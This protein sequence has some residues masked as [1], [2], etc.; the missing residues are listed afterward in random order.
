M[1]TLGFL[2]LAGLSSFILF[3]EAIAA[4]A[5]LRDSRSA[6]WWGISWLF[7]G[8]ANVATFVA[9]PPFV[10]VFLVNVG[11]SLAAWAALVWREQ[12]LVKTAGS[13]KGALLA[14]GTMGSTLLVA[15]V[16]V[17][18]S[19]E[20]YV[21]AVAWNLVPV[22]F[23][24]LAY[25]R[26]PSR[27][28]TRPERFQARRLL[29]GSCLGVLPVFLSWMMVTSLALPGLG[30]GVPLFMAVM[31]PWILRS[32]SNSDPRLNTSQSGPFLVNRTTDGVVFV[33][34]NG[35][36][37]DPNPAFS[38]LLGWTSDEISGQSLA[39]LG[40]EP[41]GQ[42][43]LEALS[44]LTFPDWE[45]DLRF[46]HRDGDAVPVRVVFHR[47]H[48]GARE[49]TGAVLLLYDQRNPQ[50]RDLTTRVDEVTSLSNRR[51][52][53]ELLEAE[54]QRVSQYG[55]TL[56]ALWIT[57]LEWESVRQKFGEE[58][59]HDGLQRLAAILQAGLRKTD[60]SGRIDEAVFVVV[61]PHTTEERAT[62]VAR[63]LER[64][65]HLS[66]EEENAGLQMEVLAGQVN[67]TD[68]S[69]E[70]FLSRIRKR[71]AV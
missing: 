12:I 55:G 49:A 34:A 46:R 23:M 65:F 16:A 67:N 54:Y 53:L 56:S 35:Q 31:A 66:A 18:W 40:G 10:Q 5:A 8:A 38:G 28:W 58:T 51:W 4:F 29:I 3:V 26:A 69:A 17:S 42:K 32:L 50:R 44:G 64:L 27:E 57:L 21:L 48:N 9:V 43:A 41:A 22:C 70:G 52:T 59:L 33:N 6:R 24:I 71:H 30:F 7:W 36:L 60:F 19:V 37:Q 11:F 63:R 62:L 13:W 61:L 14:L 39:Y 45:G 25:G 20:A 68:Q 15:T 2:I 47:L 1:Q